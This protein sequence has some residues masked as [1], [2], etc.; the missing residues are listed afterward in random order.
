M[1]FIVITLTQANIEHSHLYLSSYIGFFP[2]NVIGGANKSSIAE[3]LLQLNFG[4]SG[5]PVYTDIAGDKNIF[6]KRGWVKT[7]FKIHEL[8]AGDSVVI[9]KTDDLCL[10][11]Y[12][13]RR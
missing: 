1:K 6:R 4:L 11:I 13:S 2:K 3:Q 5:E 10:H 12:P 7:F 9:E 8:K